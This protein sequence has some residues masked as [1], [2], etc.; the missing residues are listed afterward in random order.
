[1]PVSR[2]ENLDVWKVAFELTQ[3][4]YT[5]TKGDLFAHDFALKDQVRRA[6]IS[7][8][9]NIAEG[10]V[11]ISKREFIR[12][13]DIARA[14]AMEVQSLLHLAL[15]EDYITKREFDE[16]YKLC[17]RLRFSL[18]TLIRHLRGQL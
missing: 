2:Y 16:M 5:V 6:S 10:F 8:I 14:S 9:A 3:T 15:S 12:F 4:V 7:T 1:M 17:E 18:T 11:R 13:L